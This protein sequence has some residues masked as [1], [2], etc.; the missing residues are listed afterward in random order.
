MRFRVLSLSA[1]AALVVACGSGDGFQGDDDVEQPGVDAAQTVDAGADATQPKDSGPQDSTTPP[2]NDATL[3]VNFGDAIWTADSSG[4]GNDGS[5][6]TGTG[7]APDGVLCNGSVAETCTNG[8]LSTKTCSGAT[9][10]CAD[11]FGCVVCDPGSGS[12]VGST[13]TLCKSDGSGYVTNN[14]DSQLGLACQG[15]VCTGD[16]AN[17]GQSYIGCEYYAV[18]SL[19]HLLDQGA[20]SF[21]VS[22]ANTTSKAATVNI[23]GP[24]AV[25]GNPFTI[26]A[27]SISP[28]VLPWESALSCGSG[29][30]VNG[31][32]Q[33]TAPATQVDVGGAYHIKSTEPVT[34]Y[35][36]NARD[37][38]VNAKCS[39]GDS[40]VSTSPPCFSY[41]N[42]A[43]LL[44]PVTALTGNYYVA[45]YSAFYNWPSLIDVVGTQAN[46]SVTVGLP[47]GATIT[48]GTTKLTTT[49][50]TVTLNAGDVLQITNP[51]NGNASYSD[52]ISGASVTADA[53]VEVFGGDSCIYTPAT[54]GYCDH[55]EEIMFPVETLRN[56][57]LVVPPEMT[58]IQLNQRLTK[59]THVVK[60][61]GTSNGTTL[62]Y[63][64]APTVLSGTASTSVGAG[65]VVTFETNTPFLVTA[66]PATHPIVVSMYME[67]SSNYC[68]PN[69]SSCDL[70]GD[71]AQSVAVASEQ[72]RNNYSFT[73][74]NNYYINWA[75]IIAPTG[76]SVTV[77]ATTIA[78]GSFTAIGATGYGYYYYKICDNSSSPACSSVSS[79]HTATSSGPFGIQVY[80]YGHDTSYWYP[81]GLNLTR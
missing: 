30:C 19:N 59:P 32:T 44:I 70:N 13:G 48:K 63:S 9:P 22:I 23:T 62:T 55:M 45:S 38:Q 79:N 43:S 76:N 56:D 14:C 75:T 41:T 81:G 5:Q 54:N 40:T 16:C 74:P 35:Q 42:D 77:D 17:I 51:T 29:P 27:N 65:G 28:I 64:P 66:T 72:F 11:G 46:T 2:T 1:C 10:V 15:G 53:P 57:Y 39:S 33:P 25:A 20:F 60:I 7:C 80:G 78:S 49:G 24:H 3:D 12:C 6:E 37:Y 36:F 69:S 47:A 68:D 50:G 67:G 58:G 21:A 18:T 8:Q 31:A 26:A 52:D 4:G 61:I 73:A 71:P 34:V